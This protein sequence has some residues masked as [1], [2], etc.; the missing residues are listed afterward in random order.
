V[1]ARLAPLVFAL[2]LGSFIVAIPN[3]FF[4]GS[5]SASTTQMPANAS[6]HVLAERATRV[7]TYGFP[8][9]AL[10]IRASTISGYEAVPSSGSRT[11][12]VGGRAMTLPNPP[13]KDAPSR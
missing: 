7:G 1:K 5:S 13:T 3:P 12:W 11:I 2:G 8:M 10:T 9:P 6:Q 4:P